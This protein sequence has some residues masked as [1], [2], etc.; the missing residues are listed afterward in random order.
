MK[1]AVYEKYGPPEI[2]KIR[3]IEKPAVLEDDH[4]LVRVH[5]A[6]VNPF[7]IFFRSGY[8]AVRLANGGL[9]KPKQHH[10]GGD[11]AGMVAAVGPAVDRFKPGDRVFGSGRGSHAEFSLSRQNA[12]ARMPLN[13][14]FNEAAALPTAGQTALEAIRDIAQVRPEQ[15]VLV[16]GASGGIGHFAVQLGRYYG[17]EV[18]AVCSKSNLDWVKDLGA[19]EVIDYIREDFARRGRKY[20]LILDAVGKR[21]FF[22][23]RRALKDTGLYIT[24]HILY[25]RYHFLQLMLGSLFGDRRAKTHLTR[26]NHESLDFLRE[27]VE[28]GDLKPVIDKVYPLT[29]IAAAHRHVENGHT[30]GKV[31]VEV[32]VA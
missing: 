23:S 27:R 12:L 4:V 11:V 2:V 24:E 10:S 32:R 6:S 28:V 25:P 3:E 15:Q 16:Y 30:K 31:V 26:T 20:D 29:K 21:T 18:T 13:A 22:N 19:Q 9:L 7:D 14:S 8:F 5:S 1:A 17:A